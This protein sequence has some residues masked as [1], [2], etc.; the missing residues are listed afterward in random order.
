MP[1]SLRAACTAASWGVFSLWDTF[2]G[3][4]Q[5]PGKH[6]NDPG[7]VSSVQTAP[8]CT[9]S[10]TGGLRRGSECVSIISAVKSLPFISK[11]RPRVRT[12]SLKQGFSSFATDMW[13]CRILYYWGLSTASLAGSTPFLPPPLE[14]GHPQKVCR[15]CRGPS[16]AK[17]TQAENH[18]SEERGDGKSTNARVPK[19][20]ICKQCP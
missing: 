9:A 11:Q 13:A 17:P 20:K 16:G 1:C 7:Q 15:H 14:L 18:G 10:Q 3:R 4:Y 19:L 6:R 5:V 12:G 2:Q 8:R